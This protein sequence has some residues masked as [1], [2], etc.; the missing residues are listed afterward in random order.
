MMVASCK[1][2]LETKV[3]SNLTPDNFYKSEGDANA[4]L[5]TLYIPFTSY[6]G[7]SFFLRRSQRKFLLKKISVS[8]LL[9]PLL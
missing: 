6:W 9:L 7:N 5:M 3:Y 4:A 1:K 2:Q 8:A